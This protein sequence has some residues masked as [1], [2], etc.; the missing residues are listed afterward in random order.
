[1]EVLLA[2]KAGFC[3]GVK[4]AVEL[5]EKT[6]ATASNPVST[7]GPLIHNPAVVASLAA[8]GVR[9]VSQPSEAAAGTI[10]VRS[11]GAPPEVIA[12]AERLGLAVVDATCPFVR[13]AQKLSQ[14]LASAGYQVVVVG[15]PGHPE[16]KGVVAAAG[17]AVVAMDA[18]DLD[19]AVLKKRVG[20][21][22]QTTLAPETL[23]R[24]VAAIVPAC[25]ELVVYNTIC[26]ATHERQRGA[27]ELARKVDAMVVVGGRESA[28]T[29][30]L[31]EICQ[32]IVPTHHVEDADDIE[33]SW[34]A[35]CARVGVTAGASTP[36]EQIEA[37]R[38][39]LEEISREGKAKP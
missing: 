15:D 13:K 20:L 3:F 34:F 9:A 31:V 4:R 24:V 32:E 29:A 12:Q 17:G 26:T 27:L 36:A 2:P 1:M 30:H 8:R 6:V 28:N 19:P 22:C 18:A 7:L 14:R 21:I 37:V 38:K 16:I 10:I 23:A 11:H 5:T 25:R 33:P 39:R 35:E